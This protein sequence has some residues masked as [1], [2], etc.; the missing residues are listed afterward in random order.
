MAE[1]PQSNTPDRS[2]SSPG[3]GE[4]RSRSSSQSS[5]GR[6]PRRSF[7]RD[8]S[9]RRRFQPRRKVC[10]FCAKKDIKINWKRPEDLR[11]YTSDSGGIFPRRKTGMC[12]KHQRRVAV[13]IKRARHM[14]LMPYTS[15]HMR[16]MGQKS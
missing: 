11:R 9:G 10:I 14:A 7:N 5:G 16:V 8:S 4:S 1:E 3:G 12:A 2:S 6:P 15:E 13:A